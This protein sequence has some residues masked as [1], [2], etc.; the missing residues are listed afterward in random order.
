MGIVSTTDWNIS[1]MKWFGSENG[2]IPDESTD[3]YDSLLRLER[4]LGNETRSKLQ[5]VEGGVM[6]FQCD[7]SSSYYSEACSEV[8]F[9]KNNKNGIDSRDGVHDRGNAQHIRAKC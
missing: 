3:S 4:S 8:D 1:A 5:E 7:C 6:T 2:Y 9:I